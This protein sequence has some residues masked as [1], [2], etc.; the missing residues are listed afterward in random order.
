MLFMEYI[1]LI[2]AVGFM[3]TSSVFGGFYTRRTKEYKEPI[4]LYNAAEALSCLLAWAILYAFNFSFAL[5]VLLY[6]LAMGASFTCCKIG[7]VNALRTGPVAL[8]SLVNALSLIGATVWGFIFWGAKVTPFAVAGIL[9]VAVALALCLYGGK[10]TKAAGNETGGINLKWLLF[11]GMSFFGN[12]ASTIVQRT[13]QTAFGGEHGEM[14]MF[15]AVSISA[16]VCGV[17]YARSDKTDSVTLLKEAGAFPV[18]A[19]VGNVLLNLFVMLL[20]TSRLS[21][22]VIYP[23]ICIGGLS[24]TIL[25]S[26]FAFKERLK[27]WQWL[28]IAVGAIAVILLN[29]G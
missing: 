26:L 13:Q 19:G 3:S 7:T 15:F 14:L 22:S 27:R 2:A 18:A 4:P 12:T 16:A 23:T 29:L 1:Y 28:G 25:F 5:K 20:A 21:S 17:F 8:T 11:V 9:L 10:E 6:S 24:L